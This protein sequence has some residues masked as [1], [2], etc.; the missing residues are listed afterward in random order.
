[1]R[2]RIGVCALALALLVPGCGNK[3]G[4]LGSGGSVNFC[5]GYHEYAD[6]QE[7]SPD[8][9]TEVELY[10]I[11]MLRVVDRIK[12][13]FRIDL[14]KGP[15]LKVP[16]TVEADLK[17]VKARMIRLRDEARAA[18]GDAAKVRVAVNKL[19]DDGGYNDAEGRLV[20]FAE[21][22]CPSR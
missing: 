7:P 18:K 4:G 19:A 8:D 13:T 11:A 20:D 10:T 9:G 21:T 14:P 12:I 2:A 17:T 6:F 1:V 5:R 22:R 15:P 3:K 16:A